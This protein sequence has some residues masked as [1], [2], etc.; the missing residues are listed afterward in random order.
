MKE[1]R[2]KQDLRGNWFTPGLRHGYG[3]GSNVELIEQKGQRAI[4]KIKGA[5]DWSGIGM[6]PEY[7]ET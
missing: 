6:K 4:I 3:V 1:F 7:F 5:A 2:L